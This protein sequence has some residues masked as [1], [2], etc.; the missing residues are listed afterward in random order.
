M[1]VETDHRQDVDPGLFALLLSLRCHG[2]NAEVELVRR[3]CGSD[4]VGIIEML[5][6]AKELGLKVRA[7]TANWEQLARTPVPVIAALRSGG[8]FLIT[9]FADDKVVVVQP[10]L[11]RP[12]PMKRAEFETVWDGRLVAMTRRSW[13][14]SLMHRMIWQLT[15]T[16]EG[17]RRL[18]QNIR[19]PLMRRVREIDEG[20]VD[21][22]VESAETDPT[23]AGDPG[24]FALVMLLRSRHWCRVWADSPPVR[25]GH[26]RHHRDAALR[27][28]P[29]AQ[30][31]RAH[32]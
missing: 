28:R 11:A 29:R 32:D 8:F 30:G 6:C 15:R 3:R 16:A 13:L 18:A 5:R 19:Q 1:T 26:H 12:L 9:K 23:K 2:I 10:G 24:L 25:D 21:P 31:A 4:T 20:P 22:A 17:V 27:E 14:S 7:P